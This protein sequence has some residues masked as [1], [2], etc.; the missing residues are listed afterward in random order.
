MGELS[1]L[2]GGHQTCDS[3]FASFGKDDL[4]DEL[5]AWRILDCLGHSIVS[6]QPTAAIFPELIDLLSALGCPD[7]RSL[8][9]LGAQLEYLPLR[10]RFDVGAKLFDDAA[11]D[12]RCL[13]IQV[14]AKSSD[15]RL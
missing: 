13:F 6:D 4:P 9:I 2:L 8:H 15:D 3:N 14:L 11:H 1:R 7:L 10:I 12:A 5:H